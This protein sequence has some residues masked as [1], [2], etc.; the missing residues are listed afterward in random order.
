MR[1]IFL[2]LCGTTARTP[3]IRV[4]VIYESIAVVLE[5]LKYILSHVE[6]ILA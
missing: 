1:H 5:D 4:I 6:F 3:S 2:K